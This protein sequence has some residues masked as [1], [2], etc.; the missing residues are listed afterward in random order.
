MHGA[1]KCCIQVSVFRLLHNAKR[2]VNNRAD[3]MREDR[4]CS[5][6]FGLPKATPACRN[7]H[8]ATMHVAVMI[9]DRYMLRLE[10]RHDVWHHLL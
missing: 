3:D 4:S 10:L 5:A 7:Y 8:E 1:M 6:R 9:G 2:L